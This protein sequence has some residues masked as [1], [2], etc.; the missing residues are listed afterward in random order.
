MG[1]NVEFLIRETEKGIVAH[2]VIVIDNPYNENNSM[3]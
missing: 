3:K 2:P 1:Q